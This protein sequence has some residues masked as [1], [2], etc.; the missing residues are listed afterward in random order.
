M[1]NIAL[2]RHFSTLI[3]FYSKSHKSK[4]NAM[5]KSICKNKIIKIIRTFGCGL[6]KVKLNL[7]ISDVFL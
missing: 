1:L 3:V 4:K 5:Y 2:N 6:S 7:L